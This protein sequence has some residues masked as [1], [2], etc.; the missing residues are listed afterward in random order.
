LYDAYNQWSEN[1]Q[2]DMQLSSELAYKAL[3]LD[4]S[5]STALSALSCGDWMQRRFDQA[6]SWAL[7]NDGKPEGALRAAEQA[8]R[9][10][11]A[12]HDRYAFEAGTAYGGMGRYQEAVCLLKQNVAAYPNNLVAHL[13]LA[14]NYVELGRD[15]DARAEAAEIMRISPHFALA[16]MLTT[17]DEA[18][19]KRWESDLRKAGLK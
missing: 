15:H 17:K 18:V 1:P 6:L 14:S 9:L 5:N 11:P 13:L 7:D 16:Y 12:Q 19:N 3:A 2:A 8:M 4:D 10:D